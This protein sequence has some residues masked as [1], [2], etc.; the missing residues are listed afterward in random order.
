M[1]VRHLIRCAREGCLKTFPIPRNRR[2]NQCTT[3][4]AQSLDSAYWISLLYY[5]AI[6]QA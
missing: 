6:W 3:G 4:P 5:S 2:T 1:D